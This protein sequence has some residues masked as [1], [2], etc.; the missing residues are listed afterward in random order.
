MS[1]R[2]LTRREFLR[3]AGIGAGAATLAACAPVAAPTQAPAAQQPAGEQAAEA[4]AEAP[5]ASAEVK[6]LEL[7]TFVN[8]HARWFRSM[9][10]DYVKEK[11]P[12]FSLNVSEIAYGDMHDKTQIALQAGGVGAPDLVDLE[13]GRFGGFLRGGGDPGL[14]D[15][16]DMLKGGGYMEQLVAA[17]QA[18]YS[19]KGKMYGIEHAL[20]PCV[21]YYRA[22]VYEEAGIDVANLATWEDWIAAVKPLVKDDIVICNFP[23]HELLLRQ[24]GSDYFDVDGNVT[25]DTDQSIEIMQ[26]VLDLRDVHQIARQGPAGDAWYTAL[27]EGKFLCLPTEAD[28]GAGFLRD[29]VPDGKGKWKAMPLPARTAG[30]SRTSCYG[31]TGN[32][33]SKYSKYVEDAWAF[34]QYSMLSVE[35]NVRRFLETALWPPFIP[36]MEDPRLHKPDEYYSGQDLGAVFAD[37]A[38]GVP[39]QYQS[40][41]RSEL[42]S[43]LSPFWQDIYDGKVMHADAFKEV[44]QKVRDIM[45]EEGAA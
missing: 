12:N 27:K 23:N 22:D 11:D 26:W 42:N 6:K 36:A 40:P 8:T 24:A 21:S 2:R 43:L 3:L 17:R 16:T 1:D 15:L 29:N 4:P 7:W 32:C 33:I 25:L 37:V 19:Y 28:W 38:P 20:T 34:Q 14:I 9:A 35:G 30:G 31:G 13:Q 41:Y 45:A 44:A 10:E 5:A 39:A 18:L